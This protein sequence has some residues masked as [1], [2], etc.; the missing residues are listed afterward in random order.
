MRRPA[1][2]LVPGVVLAAHGAV[3]AIRLLL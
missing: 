2:L 3:A 1:A